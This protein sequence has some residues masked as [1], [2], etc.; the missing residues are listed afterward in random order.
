VTCSCGRVA[1]HGDK[2]HPCYVRAWRKRRK[3][4][5]P[6]PCDQDWFDWEVVR[7]RWYGSS[8]RLPT[9]AERVYLAG[10]LA[11]AQLGQQTERLILGMSWEGAAELLSDVREGR[12]QVPA[13]AW[14]GTA[15]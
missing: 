12:V 8:T 6:L 5:P 4:L 15:A 10:L 14:D 1:K 3:A 11:T 13:R 7:K 2:C 9:K